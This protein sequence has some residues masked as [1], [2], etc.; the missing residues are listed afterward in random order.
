M[1]Q[2]NNGDRTWQPLIELMDGDA[3]VS[4][5]SPDGGWLAYT[6]PAGSERPE[7]VYVVRLPELVD[8]HVV[9]DERGGWGPLWSPDGQELYY[10]R[11]GDGAM[12]SV[13][14]D[15]ALTP[16]FRPPEV[17]FPNQ[18]YHPL[19]PQQSAA[20]FW[21]IA[22]D[23]RFLMVKEG[24]ESTANRPNEIVVVVNWLEELKQRVPIR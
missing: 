17:L 1:A 24:S 22:S 7:A 3:S 2:R 18:R 20:R 4:S 14:I 11:F 19:K 23:G 15:T 12:M 5:V 16:P 13:R 6:A 9:S 21:D 10:R 8:R